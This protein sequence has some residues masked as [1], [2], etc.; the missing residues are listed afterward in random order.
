VVRDGR[1]RFFVL[2]DDPTDPEVKANGGNPF[3]NVAAGPVN[4]NEIDISG[5]RENTNIREYH[6]VLKRISDK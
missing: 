6:V 5:S 1:I 4:G 2:H 3:H